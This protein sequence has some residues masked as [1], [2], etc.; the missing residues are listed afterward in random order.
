MSI[1]APK[2]QMHGSYYEFCQVCGRRFFGHTLHNRAQDGLRVCSDDNDPYP[3]HWVPIKIRA[4]AHPP[5]INPNP[6][7]TVRTA[8]TFDYKDLPNN[9]GQ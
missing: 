8:P 2:G 7:T 1:E 5:F 9:A 4:E 6:D 3:P